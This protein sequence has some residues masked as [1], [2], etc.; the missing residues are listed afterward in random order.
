MKNGV[1]LILKD[2]FIEIVLVLAFLVLIGATYGLV[3]DKMVDQGKQ[4]VES[5]TDLTSI[6]IKEQELSGEI[7]EEVYK[8][9]KTPSN[10]HDDRPKFKEFSKSAKVAIIIDDMGKNLLI[11]KQLLAL[12]VPLGIAILPFKEFSKS[13]ALI[14]KNSAATVILHLPME[15]KLSSNNPGQGALTTSMSDSKLLESLKKA[16]ENVPSADGVNNH[17]GSKFT[18][19][20]KKMNIVLNEIKTRGL[21]FV[22]SK[23]TPN[24]TAYRAAFA[25]GLAVAQ[26]DVFL[27]NTRNIDLI[28]GNISKLAELAIKSGSAIGIGH[29]Y[30]E[31]LEALKRTLPKLNKLGVEVVPITSLLRS[32]P[33]H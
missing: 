3:Y 7:Y 4:E 31:T 24:S 30:P 18:E 11:A 10:Q 1:L 12:D 8:E 26:R 21:F 9:I 15:P 6:D 2:Y 17:M 23:T 16:L 32:K 22:D 25:M 19:D 14:T 28:E 13:T 33:T 20:K 27:D 29:P 5:L